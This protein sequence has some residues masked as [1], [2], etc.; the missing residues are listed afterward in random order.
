MG[1]ACN[2]RM[3]QVVGRLAV[4]E[5][6]A[7][8]TGLSRISLFGQHSAAIKVWQFNIKSLSLFYGK[9]K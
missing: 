9:I 4:A 5:G 3:D 8:R 2:E 6:Q 1:R 7:E